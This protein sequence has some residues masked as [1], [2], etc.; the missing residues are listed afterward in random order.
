[1]PGYK[2]FHPVAYVSRFEN[3]LVHQ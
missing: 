2:T 3:L 1:M